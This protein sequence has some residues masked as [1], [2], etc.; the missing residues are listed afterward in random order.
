MGRSPFLS[1]NRS[2]ATDTKRLVTCL[3]FKIVTSSLQ[4]ILIMPGPKVKPKNL[5]PQALILA[6]GQKNLLP[7]FQS[8][9]KG[10]LWALIWAYNLTHG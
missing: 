10:T 5:G 3:L 4:G 9:G 6:Q 7:Q 8:Y 1:S 2:L